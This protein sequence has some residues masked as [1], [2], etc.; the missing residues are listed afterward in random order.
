MFLPYRV[1][2]SQIADAHVV[3]TRVLV[4]VFVLAAALTVSQATASPDRK[5]PKSD[6]A[7]VATSAK[8]TAGKAAASGAPGIWWAGDIE[9]GWGVNLSG[10]R[11]GTLM[12]A[13]W[14]TYDEAG[15]AKWFTSSDC[16]VVANTCSGNLYDATGPAFGTPFDPKL[17]VPRTVGSVRFQFA[18]DRRGTMEFTVGNVSRS[19]DIERVEFANVALGGTGYSDMWWNPNESG[20]GYAIVQQ[21][22]I[23][24]FAWYGYDADGKPTWYTIPN[25]PLLTANECTGRVFTATGPAFGPTFDRLRVIPREVGVGTLRFSD[26]NNG[27]F[28]YT[29]NC[30]GGSNRIERLI[31]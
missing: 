8:S 4:M 12:F 31:Y 23:I 17:V 25:C 6:S 11:A 24:F 15:R 9:N 29:V 20:Q 28:S 16:K 27:V 7:Q 14:Y 2:V 30:T 1:L 3:L 18:S 26:A 21:G 10:N 22:N 5:A 19:V 13:A